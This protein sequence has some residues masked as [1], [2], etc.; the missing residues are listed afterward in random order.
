MRQISRTTNPTRLKQIDRKNFVV[1]THNDDVNG[2]TFWLERF[3][4]SAAGLSASVQIACI[5]HA[6]STEDYFPLGS[7]ADFRRH[8]FS[9]RDLA[10]DRPLKF[11]FIFNDPGEP[12]LVGYADGIRAI[13]E[14]G[15]LGNSLVDIE[16]ADLNGIAWKLA[17]PASL[18]ESGAK[19]NVL[20]ERTLFPTAQAAAHSPWFGV[21]VMPEVM[22]QIATVIAEQPG[23]LEDPESWPFTWA[24]YLS[25]LGVDAPFDDMEDDPDARSNWVESVV[26]S[27]AAKGVLR[28]HM[29]RAIAEMDGEAK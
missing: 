8:A 19:P 3:D 11:R 29:E 12:L 6:G 9:I 5:A 20:V 25:A 15:Q 26:D 28:H 23:S 17:L 10:T 21:L 24:E 18:H 16:P 13:E 2:R 27:F 7:V 4:Y 1:R 14:S 22:R